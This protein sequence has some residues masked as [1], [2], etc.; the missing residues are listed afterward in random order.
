V[1]G[2]AADD[3]ALIEK[4]IS[5]RQQ[6]RLKLPD[7]IIAAMAMLK[8]AALVTADREFAKA[9]DLTVINWTES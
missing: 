8:N 1:A 5:V 3:A 6:H 7:A 4:I 2:L 9:T